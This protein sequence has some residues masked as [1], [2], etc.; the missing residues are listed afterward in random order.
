MDPE[1]DAANVNRGPQWRMP[2]KVQQDELVEVCT[3]IWT[4]QN[5]VKGYLVTAP[6][7]NTIF[8]PA[9]GYKLAEWTKED[10]R[11]NFPHGFYW[12]ST[13]YSREPIN[14]FLIIFGEARVRP[15]HDY[16]Y[17]GKTVRAVRASKN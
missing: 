4:T 15:K 11:S 5:S 13:L 8:L 16:R 12:S 17:E 2:A 7:G 10:S 9:A 3:W 14:A 1:D 6:N